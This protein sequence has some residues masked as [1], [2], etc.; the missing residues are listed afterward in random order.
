MG[1]VTTACIAASLRGGSSRA[2]LRIA[3]LPQASA[4]DKPAPLLAFDLDQQHTDDAA[5]AVQL[6][7]GQEYL[8]E[9]TLPGECSSVTTE[10]QEAFQ[11]DS[12]DGL[13]GRLRPGTATG[14]MMVQ[15]I[16]GGIPI[17]R[18][19]LEVRSRKL[20][21]R[22][23]YRWMLR[24]IAEQMTELIMDRFAAS[25]AMFVPT[26]TSDAVT[27]YQRFAFLRSLIAS[28][29]FQGALHELLRR[30]HV[31][32]GV[33]HERVDP[34]QGVKSGSHTL[35]Q[36]GGPGRR[37][38]WPHGPIASLPERLDRRRTDATHD[39]VPNRFVRFAFERWRQVIADIDAALARARPSPAT[40]RGRKEVGEV[41]DLL[42]ETLNHDLFKEVG[43]LPH[44]PAENQVLQRREGYRDVFKAYV[45]FEL[46][47]QLSWRDEESRFD[48]GQR[49]VAVLYEYWVFVQLAMIV[50]ELAG[51][52]FDIRP[53]LRIDSDG[54]NVSLRIGRETVLSGEAMRFGRRLFVELCFNRTF[55]PGRQAGSWTRSMRPDY[56]L[57][58]GPA[59]T[60]L[61]AF[62]PVVIHFDAKYRVQFVKE[63][64][65]ADDELADFEPANS[66][67][68]E[69]ARG[70]PLRADLLKMHAYRDAIRR[71]AGAYV[72]Y[73]GD[74]AES[75]DSAFRE[76]HELLPGLGAFVLR[77]AQDG[78]AAGRGV[79]LRFLSDVLDHVATR[80]TAHERGRYWLGEVY[81]VYD[82]RVRP[83]KELTEPLPE[84]RVL[85]GYV[86]S[87]AHWDWIF[88]TKTY[89]VRTETRTG[90][91]DANAPLLYCQLVLLYCP[92]LDHALLVRV[93]S[94]PERV[95]RE[96]ME[97]TGYPE[98]TSDYWC[99][100]LAALSS[101]A[102][103]AALRAADLD[104]LVRSLG[105]RKG[106]PVAVTWLQ[107]VSM[108]IADL[109]PAQ[110]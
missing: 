95:T 17:A 6:L 27:L 50:A 3:L 44:F 92:S 14:L 2:L 38:P 63:L 71:S 97:R 22:S 32:W 68:R 96:A 74:D 85:L 98:P 24:D 83:T 72:I 70:G 31:A 20:G 86:K 37:V 39:T 54:L 15:L 104:L 49:D 52:D 36:I 26:G 5:S 40:V 21:Y 60:E 91:V 84:T 66:T 19:E 102:S 65:G 1:A 80:L 8:Y 100:Q 41:L 23:E 35:R 45:E 67:E 88:R 76:Y 101:P 110:T 69:P 87:K 34:G 33:T 30:P 18:V 48:A 25:G 62:E 105:R 81:G 51:Q 89:N 103:L 75:N 46:A 43:P 90:G 108:G 55:S 79:L 82:A 13:R 109:P 99:I 77:P 59:G 107:I 12:S 7:E 53:L 28:E 61:A 42:D 9:W 78:I 4:A 56:S 11:P 58:I 16:G 106:E 93:L 57:F 29:T 73:P 47:A 10:P 64:F 94:S